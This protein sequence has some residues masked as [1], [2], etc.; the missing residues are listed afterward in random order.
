MGQADTQQPEVVA[1]AVVAVGVAEEVAAVAVG[2]AAVA[3]RAQSYT[4][5]CPGSSANDTR[6]EPNHHLL[7]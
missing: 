3:L 2:V 7:R 4:S 5:T 1:V 6:S